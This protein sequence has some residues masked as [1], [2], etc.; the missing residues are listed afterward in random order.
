MTHKIAPSASSK[1]PKGAPN[2]LLPTPSGGKG[3]KPDSGS[4]PVSLLEGG[5]RSVSAE[6]RQLMIAEAAYYLS[7]RRGF[8]AGR[9]MEDWLLAEQ[10]V[11]AVLSGGETVGARAA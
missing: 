10:Q 1:A 11:D 2:V 5:T 6:K 4:K 9:E 8:G 3:S 7:E